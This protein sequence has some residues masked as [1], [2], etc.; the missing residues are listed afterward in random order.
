MAL[1][2]R[3]PLPLY[4]PRDPQASHLWR[5]IDQHFDSFRQGYDER[6]QAKYGF[7]RPVVDRSVTAFLACGDLAEGFARVRCPDCHH[8][9]F[10][11]YSCKQRCTCP[12]CHQKRTLLTALHV[13][14]EVSAP[15][16]HRQV[17]LTIPKRLRLHARFDRSLLGKLAHC[18][19]TCIQA[20]VRR[21]LRR[22]PSLRDGARVVPGM[23]AAIQTHGELLHWHPHLHMLLTC[24]AF[25]FGGDFL[26]LP[27]LDL[28]RLEVAWQEAV[29]ALYLAEEKIEPEVVEN[30]RTWEHSGFSVDQSVL[31]AAG[32][33]AGIERLVQYMTRCPFSLSRL[34]KVSDKG[35]VIYKAE[36]AS[37]RSFPD[38]GG[39]GLQAGRAP[40]RSDGR[41]NYQI[42]SP[43]DFLAPLSP[44][45][46]HAAYSHQGISPD[47]LL[48]LV[49]QQEPGDAEEGGGS[50]GIRRRVHRHGRRGGSVA[51][52]Q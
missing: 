34:V 41:R 50:N 4:R 30:M 21:L 25:T 49:L 19:W 51:K 31:L 20:E 9:M 8:E 16:A 18:A 13:A 48:R 22:R 38:P 15:V 42:L 28:E 39:D 17:V 32:D 29:F 26:E 40:S 35:Q 5:L 7:W 45:T 14:Q 52:S 23:V 46:G 2:C 6:F 43:L 36:K 24:G 3:Q 44:Q 12:S 33:Q 1:A 10:V 37:C 47:P 11:A 27:E